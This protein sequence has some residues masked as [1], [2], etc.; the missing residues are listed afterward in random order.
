MRKIRLYEECIIPVIGVI[1]SIFF[2]LESRNV[3]PQSAGFPRIM[4]AMLLIFS[5]TAVYQSIKRNGSSSDDTGAIDF[6]TYK[7]PVLC[8]IG[9]IVYGI[10]IIYIGYFVSTFVF[11][12]SMMYLLKCRKW[13][14][15]SLTTVC[16]EAIVYYVFVNWLSVR[17]PNGILF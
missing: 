2:L 16:L 7:V 9:F 13:I 1:A 8:C 15:M 3:R 11:M 14:S 6:K 12:M 17:F 5:I 10:C 4:A